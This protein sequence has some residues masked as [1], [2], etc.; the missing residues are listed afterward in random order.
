MIDVAL[1][2]YDLGRPPSPDQCRVIPV[3]QAAVVFAAHPTVK[4]TS[5]SS[6]EV[7]AIYSGEVDSW[8]EGGP[9]VPLLREQGDSSTRVARNGI[10]GFGEAVDE[11]LRLGRWPTLLTDAEMGRALASTPGSVGL[12]DLGAIALEQTTLRPLALDG[13]MPS[14]ETLADGSY[15]LRRVMALVVRQD[16][17]A[18]VGPFIEFIRSAQGLEVIRSSGGYL[19]LEVATP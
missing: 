7:V 2:T 19:P 11:A 13:V 18:R 15:P 9:L 16:T 14:T 3:A 10:P 8:P 17:P 5:I 4:A 6:N 1:I 12:F